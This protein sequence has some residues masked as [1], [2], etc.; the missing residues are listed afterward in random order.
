MTKLQRGVF[1]RLVERE[2]V[3]ANIFFLPFAKF[4]THKKS[5]CSY[6]QRRDPGAYIRQKLLGFLFLTTKTNDMIQSMTG[7]QTLIYQNRTES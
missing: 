6:S 7:V 1:V 2:L 3:I 4:K 5:K